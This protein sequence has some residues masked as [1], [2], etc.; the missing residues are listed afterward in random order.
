M[1]VKSSDLLA[2]L[3]SAFIA[4]LVSRFLPES[5]W[6]NY[7]YILISYNLFLIWL[8][9]EAKQVKG[10][11]LP[12][13]ISTLTHAVCLV[14][15]VPIGMGN[16]V[17][18]Y[19]EY[20]RFCV[21]TLAYIERKWLISL[22]VKKMQEPPVSVPASTVISEATADDN[23]A[24]IKYLSHRDP[25]LQKPGMSIK[26]EYEQWLAARAKRLGKTK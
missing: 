25:R 5:A 17:I 12:F 19:F 8:V 16:G 9:I 1:V 7:E 23:E 20:V 14:L 13:G 26:N 3:V 24:W 21:P 10:I 2:F 18:P 22:G 6:Y 4:N 11:S 15:I